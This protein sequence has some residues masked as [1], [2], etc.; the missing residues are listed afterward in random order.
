MSEIAK[1]E[2]AKTSQELPVKR[3]PSTFEDFDSFLDSVFPRFW[4]ANW[5]RF[6]D[7]RRPGP[8]MKMPKADVIDGKEY[9]KVYIEAPGVKKDDLDVSMSDHTV[10]IKGKTHRK[11]ETKETDYYRCEIEQGE[12]SRT[13]SLPAEV[14]GAKVKAKFENG[15]IELTIPKL[16]QSKRHSIKID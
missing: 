14:D 3:Y 5:D 7:R 15:V 13:I 4:P 2:K 6:W 10:T 8:G 1:K 11:D 12:F 16:E 9:V